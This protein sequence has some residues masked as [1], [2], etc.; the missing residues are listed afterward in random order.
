M[1]QRTLGRPVAVQGI[2]LHSGAPVELQL[3]PAPADS[4]I[5]F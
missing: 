3:E 1:R 5:T 2:G 4:G